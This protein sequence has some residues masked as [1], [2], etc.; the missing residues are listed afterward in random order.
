[1]ANLIE[2]WPLIVGI[3]YLAVCGACQFAWD[4]VPNALTFAALVGGFLV[5][6]LVQWGMVAGGGGL[7]ASFTAGFIGFIVLLGLYTTGT[8]GAGC[9]KCQA[10]FGVWLGCTFAVGTAAQ[11]MLVGSIIAVVVTYGLGWIWSK[12]DETA[13]LFPAQLTIS[14]ASIATVLFATA[15]RG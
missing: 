10:T 15:M 11:L 13:K 1:M 9:V 4:R 7:A 14:L 6:A 3:I 12:L 8:L 2:S 5:S